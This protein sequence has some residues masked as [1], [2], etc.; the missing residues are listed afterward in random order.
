M[1]GWLRAAKDNYSASQ[2]S[3]RRNNPLGP[4][5]H[6]ARILTQA[7]RTAL[8]VNAADL[9]RNYA[10]AAWMIRRHLD[11]V[12][13]HDFLPQTGDRGLDQELKSY[14][15]GISRP[16]Y[17]SAGYRCGREKFF[18]LA[19]A[20][21]VLDGDTFLFL[22]GDGRVEG[23]Q[24]DRVRDPETETMKAESGW[25]QGI[26]TGA[27]GRHL[28]YSIYGRSAEGVGYRDG[29]VYPN[30]YV[31]PYGFYDR[32]EDDMTRG[33]SPLATA[34]D[35]LRDTYEAKTYALAKAKV[36]Q[37]MAL[38]IFKQAAESV[39]DVMETTPATEADAA[40]A[41]TESGGPRYQVDFGKGPVMLDLDPGDRAEFLESKT[42]STEFVAFMMT[43]IMVA[44]KALD[45]PYS[46]YD[47]KHTNF[48]GSRGAW[49]H[50]ERACLDK[51]TDQQ[52]LRRRWLLWRLQVGIQA[53][54]ISLPSGMTLRDLV[55]RWVPLGMPWWKPSE[56]IKGTVMGIG[57]GLD[58]PQDACLRTGSVFEENV[59]KTCEAIKF[60]E[61]E[62]NRILGRPLP[63]QFEVQTGAGRPPTAVED[64]D[65]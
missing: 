31:I 11:Y 43:T 3:N 13:T 12:A 61:D 15:T 27:G 22:I 17:M 5:K 59:T 26:R 28:A 6:E 34:L 30:R 63:L 24:G 45:I 37:L 16:A 60:A 7:R 4:V 8:D 47:E 62:G 33:V 50:Y 18:R 49:L 46:F 57:A 35:P 52:E 56:E 48:F 1:F 40:D 58:N 36:S 14:V 9:Q 54:D 38:A 21:R 53:G 10:I 20:R 29:N 64:E 55:F 19:E 42:P 25:V 2:G 41:D 39:G 32:Y 65:E 23:I 51:R 44:L